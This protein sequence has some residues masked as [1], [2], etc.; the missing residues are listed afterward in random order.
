MLEAARCKDGMTKIHLA[1]LAL[2]D[3]VIT[4]GIF[5][6][7]LKAGLLK[8]IRYLLQ[9]ANLKTKKFMVLKFKSLIKKVKSQ[10]KNLCSLTFNLEVL[11]KSMIMI[12]I[13]MLT[14]LFQNQTLSHLHWSMELKLIRLIK[15]FLIFKIYSLMPMVLV[16]AV[17]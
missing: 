7:C 6:N 13:L 14:I 16:E 8:M 2:E 12:S 1:V 11:A 5:L 9:E 4:I 17:D 3:Q 10:L 15:G